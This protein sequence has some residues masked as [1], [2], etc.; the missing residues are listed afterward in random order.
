MILD[1]T[2]F[3][4]CESNLNKEGYIIDSICGFPYEQISLDAICV[5]IIWNPSFLCVKYLARRIVTCPDA[6]RQYQKTFSMQSISHVKRKYRPF[7][8]ST[9]DWRYP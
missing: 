3:W 5:L 8:K 4:K 6:R 7:L 2:P 9:N 1:K